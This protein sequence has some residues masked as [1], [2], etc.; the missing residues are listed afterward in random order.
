[1]EK[2]RRQGNDGVVAYVSPTKVI[3]NYFNTPNSTQ[4]SDLTSGGD[5]SYKCAVCN[6]LKYLF[7]D[8]GKTYALRRY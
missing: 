3:S 2:V 8:H 7:H 5:L 1:M 6:L 4:H